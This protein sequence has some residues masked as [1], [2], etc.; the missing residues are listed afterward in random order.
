MAARASGDL[1]E[2]SRMLDRM[3]FIDALRALRLLDD[4]CYMANLGQS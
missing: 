3:P 2:A 1:H 4:G